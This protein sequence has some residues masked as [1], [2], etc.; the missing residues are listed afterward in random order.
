MTII[1]QKIDEH[2]QLIERIDYLLTQTVL[3]SLINSTAFI[4]ETSSTK[5]DPRI[6]TKLD[7][8]RTNLRSAQVQQQM[9]M[10]D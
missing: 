9:E 3:P 8:I 4:H 2:R 6:W 10:K 7:S 5:T 1:E